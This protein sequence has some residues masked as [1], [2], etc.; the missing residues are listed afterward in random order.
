M[1]VAFRLASVAVSCAYRDVLYCCGFSVVMLYGNGSRWHLI[2]G[3][4]RHA[5]DA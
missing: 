4:Q 1:M 5:D 2:A 3:S